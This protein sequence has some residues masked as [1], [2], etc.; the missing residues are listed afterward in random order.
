MSPKSALHTPLGDGYP[1]DADADVSMVPIEAGEQSGT[2][3]QALDTDSI[4]LL[5]LTEQ[6]RT[7]TE[8]DKWAL[9]CLLLQHV[10]RFAL[11]LNPARA[12]VPADNASVPSTR[13]RTTLQLSSS[14]C[15]LS[16]NH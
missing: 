4:P 15:L 14:V 13:P 5:G 8:I 12:I 1:D 2:N 3:Q 7:V 9:A 11:P 6:A 16:D 10:S